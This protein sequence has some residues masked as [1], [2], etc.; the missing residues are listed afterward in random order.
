MKSTV[1]LRPNKTEKD[2]IKQLMNGGVIYLSALKKGTPGYRKST[3]KQRLAYVSIINSCGN[4]LS[5]TK[6]AGTMG[7]YFLNENGKKVFADLTEK[8]FKYSTIV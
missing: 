5:F 1:E 3:K 8:V 4:L 2:V 6:G 7:R